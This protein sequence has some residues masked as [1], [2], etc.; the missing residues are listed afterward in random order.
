MDLAPGQGEH[1]DDSAHY[2]END[3]TGGSKGEK[4]NPEVIE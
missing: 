4:A 3:S 1:V 2:A